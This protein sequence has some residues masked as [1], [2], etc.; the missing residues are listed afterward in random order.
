MGVRDAIQSIVTVLG[1]LGVVLTA[2]EYWAVDRYLV[3]F[4][5]TP[6]EV[7]LDTTVLLIR[8]ATVLVL[9]GVLPGPC[10]VQR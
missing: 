2:V 9:F 4:G 3:Q 6:E 5:V 7:G 10:G 8:V 1:L